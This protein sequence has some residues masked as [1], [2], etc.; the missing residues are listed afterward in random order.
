MNKTKAEQ[1]LREA[2]FTCYESAIFGGD[3]VD[4]YS[5]E[6][7]W[8]LVEI[9]NN[10][11]RNSVAS[12]PKGKQVWPRNSSELKKLIFELEPTETEIAEFHKEESRA[13]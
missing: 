12:R 10:P 3:F 5:K 13:N 4:R 7:S 6:N 9:S 1:V 8:V 2:G 11:N